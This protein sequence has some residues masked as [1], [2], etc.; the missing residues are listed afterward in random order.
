MMNHVNSCCRKK[1]HRKCLYDIAMTVLPEDFFGL[2]VLE[3]IDPD[4]DHTEASKTV[5]SVF[6]SGVAFTLNI[7]LNFLINFLRL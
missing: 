5:A 7:L 1:L 4:I 6:L 3:K 2:L